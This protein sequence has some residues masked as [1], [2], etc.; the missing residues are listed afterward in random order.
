[1]EQ[2]HVDDIS[3]IVQTFKLLGDKT[4]L[5]IMKLLEH[6]ECCVC[7]LVEIINTS[8]PAVSQHL[9]K[10]KDAGLVKE[11]RRGQWVFYS[12]NTENKQYEM[13]EKL[14]QQLPSQDHEFTLLE[15]KGLRIICN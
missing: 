10:L 15:N 6:Q 11:T 14:I 9:R 13:V 1:M 2:T 7:E 4:R 12:L 3:I 5:T 8:Q